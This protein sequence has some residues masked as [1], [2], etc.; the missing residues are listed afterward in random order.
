MTENQDGYSYL[1]DILCCQIQSAETMYIYDE[2]SCLIAI[3]QHIYRCLVEA[4]IFAGQGKMEAIAMKLVPQLLIQYIENEDRK[5]SME[6]HIL[7]QECISQLL[8]AADDDIIA[9]LAEE[10]LI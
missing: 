2:P 1:V 5:S 7:H 8:K 3:I 10:G 9:G 6:S 4:T